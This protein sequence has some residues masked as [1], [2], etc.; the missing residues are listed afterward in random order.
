MNPE[1]SAHADI[2]GHVQQIEQRQSS[3]TQRAQIHASLYANRDYTNGAESFAP[4]QFA[5]TENLIAS[6]IDTVCSMIARNRA[7]P[8]FQTDGGD[9]STQ[10]RAKKLEKFTTGLYDQLKIYQQL[11]EAFRSAG[12]YG[13]GGLKV[14]NDAGEV[15]VEQAIFG[16]TPEIIVD[17]STCV[18]CDPNELFQRKWVDREVLKA[19]YPQHAEVIEKSAPDYSA[20]TQQVRE[21]KQ[22]PV[23]MAWRLP[24][25]RNKKDGRYVEAIEGA[26]LRDKVYKH[27][28][29]PFVFFRWS[30]PL[31]G[32]YGQGLAEQLVG[33]QL[34]LNKI[35]KFIARCQDLIAVPRIFGNFGAKGV[36]MRLDNKIGAMINTRDGRPPTFYTPPAV[37]NETY[38]EREYLVRR[39]YELSGVSMLSASSKKPGGLESGAALQE[40]NDIESQRFAIQAQRFEDMSCSL[41]ELIILVAKETYSGKAKIVPFKA[42]RFVET[43]AWSDVDPNEDR[44]RVDVEAASILSRSPAGRIQSVIQLTQAGLITDP[45]EARALLGHPDLERSRT[46]ADAA[47]D[48]I[49][50]VIET[51]LD[52]NWDQPEPLQDLNLGIKR[53]QMA[54]TRARRDGAPDNVLELLR[55]WID[56]AETLLAKSTPQAAPVQQLPT[57]EPPTG[58]PPLEMGMPVMNAA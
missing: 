19:L 13:T 4:R 5:L 27:D 28:C 39:A 24:T 43:I 26:T 46:L 33:I 45:A 35:N 15:V 7:R 34:R 37:A 9:W 2:F 40:Y 44:F 10:Q 51:L 52:G 29:L 38:Q 14:L 12:V 22:V 21:R 50:A 1:G 58:P 30:D 31:V 48:D 11:Q 57:P 16:P 6:C 36:G 42:R 55:R 41:A 3:V 47:F 8:T 18:A 54:Y 32:F 49:E 20:T 56:T 53:V 25:G 17:E 23:I